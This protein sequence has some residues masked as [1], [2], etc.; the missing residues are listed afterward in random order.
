ML[1]RNQNTNQEF[2]FT[3]LRVC[4]CFSHSMREIIVWQEMLQNFSTCYNKDLRST[5]VWFVCVCACV[6]LCVCH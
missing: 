5:S 3:W 2:C 1:R 6:R 4:G